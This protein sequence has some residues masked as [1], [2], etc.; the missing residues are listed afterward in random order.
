MKQKEINWKY[1]IG[2][3]IVDYNE[4]GSIKRDLTIADRKVM[5]Q[6]KYK[7]NKSYQSNKKYYKYCCNLCSFDG[8]KHYSCKE[9]IYKDEFW[10]WES[11]LIK[12]RGCS[13]CCTSPQIIINGIND[14]VTIYPQ[15]IKHFKNI[16]EAYTHTIYS[17][18]KMIYKCPNCGYEKEITISDFFLQGFSC[19]K[20]GD[21][22][23]YPNK[24]MLNVLE[25]LNIDVEVEYS[26][27]W[28]KP[29]RYDFYIPSINI[30]IEMD[31]SWHIKDNQMNGQTKEESQFIDNEKD[32][33][34]LENGI[35]VIRID[36]DYGRLENRFEYIKQ[37][38]LK[39][40]ELNN[41][42]SLNDIDWDSC[43]EYSCKN[44]VK[45]IC[46]YWRI[47]N[48]INNENVDTLLLSNIYKLSTGTISKYLNQGAKLKWCNY[49]GD[50]ERNKK[51]IES[52]S[53]PIEMFKN[54]ISL[55][56]FK[57]ARE[58]SREYEKLGIKLSNGHISN[59]ASGKRK[60]HKG[61][62]FKYAR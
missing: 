32:R 22:V 60:S 33:L 12:G 26:P 40:K 36:C 29:K 1:E 25:Q 41:L 31:G 23:S 21:G 46:E 8:G 28:I 61:F 42:F 54:G 11:S 15:S 44:L 10:I 58:I 2:Q 50:T 13:C 49:D 55:G 62:T 18:S 6:T 34:A 3:R 47:H 57:N 37:N 24:F 43:D 59:V 48:D 19:K 30:I 14:I 39:N 51:T 45:E 56:V 27:D 4:D 16:E 7:N 35:E 20:C 53:I 52:N 9:K 38:I 5:M 17:S